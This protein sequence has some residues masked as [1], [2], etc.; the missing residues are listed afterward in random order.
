MYPVFRKNYE[1]LHHHINR[2]YDPSPILTALRAYICTSLTVKD[3]KL[4]NVSIFLRERQKPLKDI[5]VG[6]K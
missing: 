5:T 3:L 1:K 2:W 6:A 4:F